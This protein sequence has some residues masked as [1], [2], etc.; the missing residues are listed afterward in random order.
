M[1]FIA[2]LFA[3]LLPA[4]AFAQQIDGQN[5]LVQFVE[6]AINII[7]PILYAVAVL[8]V[9][10]KLVTWILASGEDK[11]KKLADLGYSLLFLFVLFSI[12]GII[13]LLQDTVQLDNTGGQLNVPNIQIDGGA[14]IGNSG[15]TR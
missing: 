8:F 15:N 3:S 11:P 1:K 7:L 6:S 14:G 4:L 13:A 5:G 10:Y 9:I 2:V 12:T